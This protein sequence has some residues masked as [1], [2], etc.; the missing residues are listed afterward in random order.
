MANSETING[1]RSLQTID[2]GAYGAGSCDLCGHSLRYMVIAI[3]PSGNTRAIGAECAA[4]MQGISGDTNVRLRRIM[5]AEESRQPVKEVILRRGLPCPV[6]SL[7]GHPIT[8]LGFNLRLSFINYITPKPFHEQLNNWSGCDGVSGDE[9]EASGTGCTWCR[10]GV[11]LSGRLYAACSWSLNGLSSGLFIPKEYPWPYG[12]TS[13]VG[14]AL[15]DCDVEAMNELNNGKDF[16]RYDWLFTRRGNDVAAVCLNA[17]SYLISKG[18]IDNIAKAFTTDGMWKR[19][20]VPTGRPSSE[21][22]DPVIRE[23]EEVYEELK[24]MGAYY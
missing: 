19:D 3:D 23:M 15:R 8:G 18:Y 24:E 4:K 13:F 9:L 5:D 22:D 17:C 11:K 2:L 10:T 12:C 14:F 7:N 6:P 1:W 20:V 16:M 21:V